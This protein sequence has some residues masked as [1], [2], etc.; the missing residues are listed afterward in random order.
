MPPARA[1]SLVATLV[2]TACGAA[3][4]APP[5]LPAA[6]PTPAATPPAPPASP[7]PPS[8][9]CAHRAARY[10]LRLPVPIAS[11]TGLSDLARDDAGRFWAVEEREPPGTSPLTREMVR[12]DLADTSHP[13]VAERVRFELP[14]ALDAESIAPLSPML[15]AVGTEVQPE[16]ASD[17][18]Q[19]ADAIF[20]VSTASGT[21]R[22]DA[23]AGWSFSY[24]PWNRRREVNHGIEGLC[25]TRSWILA[26]SEQRA[27]ASPVFS[28]LE[29]RGRRTSSVVRGRLLLAHDDRISALTCCEAPDGALDVLAIQRGLHADGRSTH[30]LLGFRVAPTSSDFDATPD[31][32]VDL[33]PLYASA[34]GTGVMPNLEGLAPLDASTIAMITDDSPQ[35]GARFLVLQAS[36]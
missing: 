5:P 34:G 17:G 4:P 30:R 2:A 22:V 10:T 14:I 24:E 26:A 6:T 12:L 18:S 28:P 20:V 33:E 9:V 35:E 7:Q 16:H 27:G 3:R 29:L 8:P 1:A 13:R 11:V 36:R 19:T 31:L 15:F 23:T 32:D 21:A 25:A